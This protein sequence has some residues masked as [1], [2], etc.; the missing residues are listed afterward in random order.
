MTADPLAQTIVL[1]ACA[2]ALFLMCVAFFLT[3]WRVVNGPTLPDRIV[4]LD[5]LVASLLVHLPA[6]FFLPNGVELVLLLLAGAVALVLTG[7]G[8]FALDRLIAAPGSPAVARRVPI[9]V[10]TAPRRD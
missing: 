3:V 4:A 10:A 6:G 9:P 5:M 2:I 1:A 7:P 8:A